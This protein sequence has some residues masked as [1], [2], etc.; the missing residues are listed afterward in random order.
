MTK[1]TPLKERFWDKVKLGNPNECWEWQGAKDDGGYGMIAMDCAC[2]IKKGKKA[3]RSHRV[4]WE[5]TNGS[6]P[7]GLYVL[8]KCDNPSCCNP[9][10]L[11]LGTHA[12]NMRDMIQKGR[13]IHTSNFETTLRGEDQPNHKLTDIQVLEIR[14]LAKN[15]VPYKII[16]V[17]YGIDDTTVCNIKTRTTWKHLKVQNVI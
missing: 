16:A 11:F 8:H 7:E 6:I 9:N 1:R 4:A 5:L 14:Q 17:I 15:K 3:L 13:A 10:H 12:D 2:R